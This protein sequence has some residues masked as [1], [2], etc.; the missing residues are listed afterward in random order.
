MRRITKIVTYLII[1][2][3][4]VGLVL[5]DVVALVIGGTE[6][7]ISSVVIDASYKQPFLP[8]GVGFFVGIVSGHLFW[9]FGGKNGKH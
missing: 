1:P 8:F 5:F 4:L 2:A 7:T 3:L 9:R 6:A